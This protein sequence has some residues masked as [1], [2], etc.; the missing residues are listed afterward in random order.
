M[1]RAV[2]LSLILSLGS[3]YSAAAQTTLSATPAV[4]PAGA[5][6]TITVTGPPGHFIGIGGSS[7][8]AGLSFGGVALAL[9]NDAQVITTFQLDGSG[10]ATIAFTPPFNGTFLDRFY[11]QAVSSPSPSLVP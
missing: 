8:G 3:V 9:G 4:V 10:Q 6:A 1:P 7:V 11:L 2:V 5:A